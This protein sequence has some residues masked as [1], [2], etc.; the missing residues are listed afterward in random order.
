MPLIVTEDVID[1]FPK[2][3]IIIN[4]RDHA[5]V[6]VPVVALLRNPS[7]VILVPDI[8]NPTL[9]PVKVWPSYT[10]SN[11]LLA[12]IIVLPI[13]RTGSSVLCPNKDLIVNVRPA[14]VIVVGTTESLVLG[15]VIA[16]PSTFIIPLVYTAVLP[17]AM[18][19]GAPFDI[20]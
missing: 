14:A 6:L 17:S 2:P 15:I 10:N 13:A 18:V 1:G 8:V 20:T 12:V 4:P 7:S 11:T 9:F 19:A 16:V 3:F 5:S